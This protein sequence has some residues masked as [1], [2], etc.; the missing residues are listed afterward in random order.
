MDMNMNM[1]MNMYDLIAIIV[2]LCSLVITSVIA[3]LGYLQNYKIN[4]YDFKTI[5]NT[6]S[7]ILKLVSTLSL[8]IEKETIS[9]LTN[10]DIESEKKIIFD[11]LLSDTWT[12]IRYLL[13]KEDT[14]K[15]LMLTTNFLLLISSDMAGELAYQILIEINDLY[16]KY[17]S[18][19]ISEKKHLDKSTKKF[20]EPSDYIRNWYRQRSKSR[21]ANEQ[22]QLEWLTEISKT[23]NNPYL[24]F[25]KGLLQGD[26]ILIKS[27]LE[28]GVDPTSINILSEKYSPIDH[29]NSN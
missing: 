13:S 9:H 11:F 21:N 2:S 19:I 28:N 18:N 12:V 29:Q 14:D 6:K 20:F 16:S 4:R 26:H 5:E 24:D 22:K 7:D 8:I 10:V 17:Y 23:V 25:L 15:L 27:A 3:I 1:D